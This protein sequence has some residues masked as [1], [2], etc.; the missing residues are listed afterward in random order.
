MSSFACGRGNE[1]RQTKAAAKLSLPAPS[2]LLVLLPILMLA[3]QNLALTTAR[4]AAP[5]GFELRTIAFQTGGEIPR[6][7]TCDG[8]DVSPALSWTEPPPGTRSF[9]LIAEDPDAPGGTFVHWVAYDLPDRARQLP[10]AVPKEDEIEAGGRQGR[11][12]F[13]ATGYGGPCPPPGKPHR[14]FFKLYALDR[15]LDLQ[16]GATG[17][18]VGRAMKGHILKQAE[19][20]GRYRR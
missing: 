1:Q 17:K 10:E 19:L 3:W 20:M 5:V 11:N 18:D 2:G 7:Y 9:V 15:K 6:K 12:D 8:H 14:Y 13:A 4:G 16:A